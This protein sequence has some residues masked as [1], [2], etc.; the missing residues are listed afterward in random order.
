MLYFNNELQVSLQII[1]DVKQV[2]NGNKWNSMS[3]TDPKIIFLQY[4]ESL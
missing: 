3:D 2:P 4:C 1:Q